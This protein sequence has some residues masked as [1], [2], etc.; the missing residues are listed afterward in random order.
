MLLV[1]P[2]HFVIESLLLKEAQALHHYN[3]HFDTQRK[4]V[5]KVLILH[6]IRGRQSSCVHMYVNM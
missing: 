6:V 2:F 4:G 1:S 3:G 5:L